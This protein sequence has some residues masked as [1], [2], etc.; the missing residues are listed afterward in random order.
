MNLPDRWDYIVV[1][2]G[3]AGCVLANRLSA[4][5][6]H[7]VL[8]LEA[9]GSDRRLWIKIPAGFTRTVFDRSIGWG[10]TNAP[11][12]A[13]HSRP[14]PCPR[15]RVVGGSSS[16]NGHLYVRGQA[17]DYDDWVSAGAAGWGWAD[18]LP[19]FRRAET[20]L[21]GDA[22][23]RGH[24]GPLQVTDPRMRHPLCDAFIASL[25][26]Q[27][28]P[29]NPDYNS[30]DQ[31]GAAYYQYLIKD[32]RRFSAADAYLRPALRRPN[33]ALVTHA[34][35]TRIVFESR[36]AVGV[37][38][39][40]D[41]ALHTF[42]ADREVLLAAGAINTPALLQCSGVG[43]ADLLARSGVPV[44]LPL[45]GVGEGLVDHYAV[46]IAA[47]VR[48]LSSLNERTHGPRL[49]LEVLHYLAARQG[50]L[51]SAVA[52]A[53]GFVRSSHEVDRPDLQLLFAP[54]SYEH[55]KVGQAALERLPGLTCGVQQLRP[56]S[57]GHVR[58]SSPDPLAPPEIQPHYLVD[59]TDRATLLAGIR[60][61]RRLFATAP[62]GRFIESE[63]W[64]GSRI[65]GDEALLDFARGTGSTV[66]HPVGSC[67]MSTAPAAPVD[68]SL[69]VKGLDG[70]RVIDASV[71]PS[72]ISGNTY[73]ATVMIAEK[74]ADLVLGM[75][76]T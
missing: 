76:R 28:V 75:A 50:V 29:L 1:G 31:E 25:Q 4:S 24:D 8:V 66:Y 61:V 18:V 30:G 65:D 32:G 63:T 5:G 15:G 38:C 72:M 60:Y 59:D 70:L 46:R 36:R 2:A 41:G 19:Y 56:H 73:A 11:C 52:H 54:A 67:A 37:E 34:H 7:R 49:L 23:T 40:V 12:P 21:G 10:Y 57:R 58:I 51:A 64:P 47:R 26:A 62:L 44:L 55:G 39:R 22:A 17:R 14:I 27:G 42:R 20:R 9:G 68:P 16:I 43:P 35:A 45:Q 69:R 33:L 3:A 13:T 53:A 48:G 74:G 71:M 6:R